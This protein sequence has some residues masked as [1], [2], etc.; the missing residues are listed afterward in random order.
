MA[1]LLSLSS[2]CGGFIAATQE[3]NHP[4]LTTV[5]AAHDRGHRGV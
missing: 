1:L 3:P 5:I 2:R 4:P